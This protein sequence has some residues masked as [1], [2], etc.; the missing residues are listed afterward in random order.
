MITLLK[1][2]AGVSLPSICDAGHKGKTVN[3]MARLMTAAI[4]PFSTGT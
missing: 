3:V 4:S 1:L 2:Q